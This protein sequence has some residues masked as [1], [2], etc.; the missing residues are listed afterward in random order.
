MITITSL[1]NESRCY[2]EVRKLRWTDQVTCPHCASPKVVK[3]GY[4]SNQPAR[5]RY[6]CHTCQRRFDDLTGTVFAGHH[7][8]LTVWMLC[9]YLMG[10]NLSNTQIANE[11]DLNVSDSQRMCQTLRQML[12]EKKDT[13]FARHC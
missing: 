10:L 12:S 13:C 3:N 2:E 9:L 6:H 11:L 8:P 1:M 5:Q 7:Q 4:H